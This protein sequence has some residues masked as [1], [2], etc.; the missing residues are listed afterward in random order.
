MGVDQIRYL[1]I[2]GQQPGVISGLLFRSYAALL[3][4]EPDRRREMEAGFRDYDH[5]CF[6][7]PDTVG[8]C[9]ILTRLGDEFIGL[10]SWDPRGR[11]AKAI[12][13]H[14]CVVPQLRGRGIGRAQLTEV[15]RRLELEGVAAV[16]ASTGEHSFFAPARA[17]YQAC[18]FVET[19]R[20]ADGPDPSER[21]VYY[22]RQLL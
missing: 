8:R 14:N 16:Q 21:L 15:L 9:V 12:I 3:E 13:G 17:M 6:A 5:Q 10:A 19:H 18:D 4:A 2:T 22:R 11:P 7:N 1:P 20:A